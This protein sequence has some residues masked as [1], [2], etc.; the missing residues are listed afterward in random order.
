MMTNVSEVLRLGPFQPHIDSFVDHLH[1]KRY[2]PQ[3]VALKR[4]VVMA[5]AQWSQGQGIGVDDL[6]E[7]YLS[8]FVKRRP[9][10]PGSAIEMRALRQF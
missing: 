9:F 2:V 7:D 4:S 1:A 10:R 8:A 3:S 6:N 5:F